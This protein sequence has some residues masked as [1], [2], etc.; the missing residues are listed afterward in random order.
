MSQYFFFCLNCILQKKGSQYICELCQKNGKTVGSIPLIENNESQEL[1]IPNE[2]EGVPTSDHTGFSP[3]LP[4][5]NGKV[6]DLH[7]C[8]LDFVSNGIV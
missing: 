8:R 3:Q 4:W 6:G 1:F 2:P 5:R 7:Q